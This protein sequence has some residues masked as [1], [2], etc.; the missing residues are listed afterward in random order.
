MVSPMMR[1]II[2][3][4]V[5]H[6]DSFSF[7]FFFDGQ[8]CPSQL[9]PTTLAHLSDQ[10]PRNFAPV[11]DQ[12]RVVTTALHRLRSRNQPSYLFTHLSTA[13]L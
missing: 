7:F 5:T 9:L 13:N 12:R 8:A 3:D 4:F 11:I 2:E 6:R 1:L 10:H